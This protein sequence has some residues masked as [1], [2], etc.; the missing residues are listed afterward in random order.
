MKPDAPL[1]LLL[2]LTMFPACKKEM[3]RTGYA[4]ATSSALPVVCAVNY[5]LAYF[6]RRIGGH[7]IE[8]TF[9]APKDV[10]PAFWQPPD[11]Q[12]ASYQA[13]SLIL[14]NGATYSKWADTA[15]LPEAKV[16]DT[17]SAFQDKF[18][19]AKSSVTH[20]HGKDGVH[21]H[22]GTAFTTWLDFQQAISQADTICEAFKR[23]KPNGEAFEQ[24]AMNF[25]A[26][27]KDLL[28]LDLQME[29]LG[30]KLANRPVVAS[31]PVYQYWARRYGINLQSVLWE[32]E[33]IPTDA[34]MDDLKKILATHPARL[35]IWE[36]VPRKESVEKLKAI[37][38][39][40]AVFDPCANTPEKGDFLSVMRDNVA[41]VERVT[42]LFLDESLP[43]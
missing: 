25:D 37:G 17:S 24:F 38:V 39:E 32:P 21:S 41:G 18:I 28:V 6:A 36:G 30:K 12:I 14:M 13:A 20:S 34:Q 3:G 11:K 26:F 1:G 33:E 9:D 35:M 4:V 15:T 22:D 23:L 42:G 29:A 19:M 31:H 10:D 7:E 2:V 5:P 27:K 16:V 40:S 8:V 43:P